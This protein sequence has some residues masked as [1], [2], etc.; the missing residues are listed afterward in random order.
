MEDVNEFSPEFDSASYSLALE[1]PQA[2]ASTTSGGERHLLT[3]RA[4]DRDCSAEF[5]RVCRYELLAGNAGSS[6]SPVAANGSLEGLSVDAAGRLLASDRWLRSAELELERTGGQ[7]LV[8]SFQ[9]LAYDCA[10]KKSL[11]PA[12]VQLQLGRSCRA[13]WRGEFRWELA[14]GNHLPARAISQAGR[15]A[16]K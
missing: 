7:S 8:R 1:L 12:S 4:Q 15:R 5:G 2:R 10:G 9:V 13:A 6:T 16:D 14:G 3:V 11:A